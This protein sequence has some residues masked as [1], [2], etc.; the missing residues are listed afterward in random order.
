MKEAFPGRI[1]RKHPGLDAQTGNQHGGRG[2]LKNGFELLFVLTQRLFAFAQNGNHPPQV[3]RQLRQFSDS[4]PGGPV[5]RLIALRHPLTQ[6]NQRA[7][8]TRHKQRR[9][10]RKR[11]AQKQCPQRTGYDGFDRDARLCIVESARR[12]G[13]NHPA[14]TFGHDAT[15]NA[16]LA[17][18]VH[19]LGDGIAHP[20]EFDKKWQLRKIEMPAWRVRARRGQPEAPP[21]SDGHH[22]LAGRRRIHQHFQNTLK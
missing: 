6:G 8:P 2:R 4:S 18:I 7:D 10:W 11:N 15:D 20:Q 16:L 14:Q 22:G 9:H 3:L 13:Q 12:R 17:E 21:V 5:S 1:D 19:F